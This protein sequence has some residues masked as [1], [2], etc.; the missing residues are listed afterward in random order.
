ML[1][2]VGNIT[3]CPQIGEHVASQVYVSKHRILQLKM[4]NAILK[5]FWV[6]NYPEDSDR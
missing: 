4:R 3:K 1:Q 6:G 2:Q 5:P